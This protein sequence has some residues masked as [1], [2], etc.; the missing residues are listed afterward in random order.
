MNT[1]RG[2]K[3]EQNNGKLVFSDTKLPTVETWQQRGCGHC[4][5]P[6]TPEGHDGC[7]GTLDEKLV[8][9]AC[10]GHGETEAAYIQFWDNNCLRGKDAIE[11]FERLKG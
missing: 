7:L 6:N 1:F 2:H 11:K 3:I 10:C 4:K 9:N 5:K 8:M